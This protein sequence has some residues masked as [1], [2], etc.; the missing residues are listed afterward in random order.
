[1][2]AH[3]GLAPVLLNDGPSAVLSKSYDNVDAN[4]DPAVWGDWVPNQ[5]SDQV[6][7]EMWVKLEATQAE[8]YMHRFGTHNTSKFT[9]S[10]C[11]GDDALDFGV[12]G[13]G[14][15]P[16]AWGVIP[17]VSSEWQQIVMVYDFAANVADF[18][19][20]GSPVS[21]GVSL[22][23]GADASP[24]HF[25]TIG[26]AGVDTSSQLA[27]NRFQG[28]IA[29]TRIYGSVLT[30]QQVLDNYN[31]GMVPEPTMMCLLGTGGLLMFARRRR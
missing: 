19:Q 13:G 6:T 27:S 22:V 5:Y 7:V 10:F 28:K 18:Y 29:L 15:W 17:S 8:Q 21:T 9:M 2:G 31:A 4:G 11:I 1:V 14:A 12:G 20:D 25:L 3:S 16:Y 26:Q 30:D 24:L 23:T